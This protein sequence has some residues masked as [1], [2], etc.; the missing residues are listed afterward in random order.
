MFSEQFQ[1][2]TISKIENMLIFAAYDVMFWGGQKVIVHSTVGVDSWIE[3]IF[4]EV[5]LKSQ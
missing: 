2:I 1:K 3:D 5:C 4:Q